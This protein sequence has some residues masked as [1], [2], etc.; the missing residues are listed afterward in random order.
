MSR[1]GIFGGSFDP[2]HDGHSRAL[3]A[4]RE[5]LQL[6][7][8]ILVPTGVPPHKTDGHRASPDH[9]SAMVRLA[10]DGEPGLEV[11]DIEALA[12]ERTY[13]VDTVRT[14]VARHSDAESWYFILGDDCAANLH[15]WKGL[16]ELT[17]RVRFASIRRRG[18]APHPSVRAYVDNVEMSPFP[19][20]STDIRRALAAGH[21]SQL[22]LARAVVDYIN[23]H[24]LYASE[25]T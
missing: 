19:A 3:R 22:P 13:T 1:I 17:Q 6:D 25:P 12:H 7:R 18:V 20:A 23:R 9:R 10:T 21:K 2:I 24:G 4:A 15:R 11:N 16:E 14:L 8:V 5:Q